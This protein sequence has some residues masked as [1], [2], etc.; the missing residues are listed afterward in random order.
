MSIFSWL[1]T[2]AEAVTDS[3]VDKLKKQVEHLTRLVE[4]SPGLRTVY[5]GNNTALVRLKYGHR[6]YIDSRDITIGMNMMIRGEWEAHYTNL[7]RKIVK[8]GDTIVDVGANYGYYSVIC[9]WQ[10]GKTGQVYSFEPNPAVFKFLNKSLKANGFFTN[11]MAES[12]Q[13]GLSDY[14]GT[15]KFSFLDGD[16]GGG[17]MYTPENRIVKEKFDVIEVDVNTMDNQLSHVEKLDF[18]KIDAEGAEVGIVKGMTELIKRSPNIKILMEFYPNYI[19]K[20]TPVEAFVDDLV[21]LGFRFYKP[22]PLGELKPMTEAQLKTTENCYILM[23]K[24]A[25]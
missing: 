16:F 15:S 10:V 23:S 6:I 13:V 25:L 17:S 2:K 4:S 19:N 22:L 24:A 3:E 14:Q 5:V 21:S 12:F 1:K 18:V 7:V 20:H 11:K 8:Q 9:G